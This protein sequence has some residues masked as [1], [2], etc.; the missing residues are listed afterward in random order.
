MS[1]GPEPKI[2]NPLRLSEPGTKSHC[3]EQSEDKNYVFRNH[4]APTLSPT[5][6]SPSS[7]VSPDNRRKSDPTITNPQESGRCLRP[8][9]FSEKSWLISLP[10]PGSPQAGINHTLPSSSA[11]CLA[12]GSQG[13]PCKPLSPKPQSPRPGTQQ[14]DF[15]YPGLCSAISIVFLG[16]YGNMDSSPETPERPKNSKVRTNLPLSLQTLDQD[17]LKEEGMKRNQH[18]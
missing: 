17:D 16:S 8:G 6:S 5:I 1:L 10:S 2:L 4:W 13:V 9:I 18:H 3:E 7:L 14:A 12:Y 11:C 15:R